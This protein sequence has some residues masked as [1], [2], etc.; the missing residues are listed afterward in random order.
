MSINNT[1][2]PRLNTQLPSCDTQ[3]GFNNFI[4]VFSEKIEKG[5]D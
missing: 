5:R 1:K 2:I 4:S 3:L